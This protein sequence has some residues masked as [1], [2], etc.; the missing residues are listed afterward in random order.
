MYILGGRREES[1]I[2]VVVVVVTFKGSGVKRRGG[3]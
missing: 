3:A 2:L 1:F